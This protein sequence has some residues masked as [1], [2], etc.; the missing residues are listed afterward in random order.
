[1]S[2]K[3]KAHLGKAVRRVRESLRLTQ[4]EVAERLGI[5]PQFYGRIERGNSLPSVTMLVRM[6][7]IFDVSADTLM[8]CNG[9][10]RGAGGAKRGQGPRDSP[11]LRRLVRHLRNA[12]P[13]TI[14]LIS[15]LIDELHLPGD[16]ED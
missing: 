14:R 10:R 2:S 5:T 6:T 9:A 8:G 7:Q 11:E 16:E 12:S 3:R 13:D 15:V 1:M 4:E